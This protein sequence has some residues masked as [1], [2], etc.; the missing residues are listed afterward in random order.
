MFP[1]FQPGPEDQSRA[2]RSR[3]ELEATHME[4]DDSAGRLIYVNSPYGAWG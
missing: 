2:I 4:D 1:L 3:A